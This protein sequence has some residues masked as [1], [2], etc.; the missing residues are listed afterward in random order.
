[1]MSG[2]KHPSTGI[3]AQGAEIVSGMLSPLRCRS[4]HLFEKRDKNSKL[5]PM[6]NAQCPMPNAQFLF[7][8][9]KLTKTHA[10]FDD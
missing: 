7:L 9:E 6:P 10:N 1:M 8:F 4:L 3:L 2:A 5:Y